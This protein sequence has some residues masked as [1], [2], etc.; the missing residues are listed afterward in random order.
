MSPREATEDDRTATRV[1]RGDV[2]AWAAMDLA[3]VPDLDPEAFDVHRMIDAAAQQFAAP[4]EEKGIALEVKRAAS[5]PRL[6]LGEVEWL[7]EVLCGLMDN[8]VRFTDSGEVVASITADR[9][10]GRRVM[11][12]A[13]VSDTGCGMSADVLARLFGPRHGGRFT[14]LGG[15]DGAGTLGVAQRLVELMDGRLG[16]SS[17]LGLGTTTWFT[18]PLDLP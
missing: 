2:L 6:A 7:R 9:T 3:D 4:A 10:G 16:C 8:A 14:P 11:F 15:L 18:V 13:E 1:A 12:H 5:V 17:A